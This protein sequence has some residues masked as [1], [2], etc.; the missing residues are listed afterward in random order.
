MCGG[1]KSTQSSKSTYTPNPE[2]KAFYSD[3]LADS[4]AALSPYDPATEKQ[5][6]GF[7]PQQQQAFTGVGALQGAYQ[8]YIGE[9]TDMTRAGGA[10]ITADDIAKF[11]N[12]YQD[13]TLNATLQR[14]N[15][16]N[17]MQTRDYTASQAAQSGLGGSGFHIGKAD[18]AGNQAQS[19]DATIADMLFKG[20]QSSLGAAQADKT[21]GLQAG[22]Q[23]AGLGQLG[24]QLGYQDIAALTQ[25]GNQQ[26]AQTQAELDAASTNALNEQLYPMQQQQWLASIGSGIGPLMGGTTTG[27]A[28]TEQGK[29]IGNLIG[30]AVTL[31]GMASDDRVKENKI[32][33]G[34]TF[35]GQTIWKYNYKGDPR[36]QIGLIAQEVEGGEHPEAVRELGG[37][38]HVNY[39]EA[40]S[41]SY[42]NGG[43]IGFSG[44]LLPW[45]ELKASQPIIP[46]LPSSGGGEGQGGEQN[47]EQMFNMGKKAGAGLEKLFGGSGMP[48]ASSPAGGALA[49]SGLQ[50][51]GGAGSAGGMA[52]MG[53]IGSLLGMF[54]F[55]DGGIV[56]GLRGSLATPEEMQALEMVESGG[57][58]I[59]GPVTRSGERAQGPRQ[60]MPSTARDP[61]FGVAPLPP[62]AGVDQQRQ[63]SDAYFNAMLKR[64]GGDRDAARIA[65]NGGPARADAWLKA[66]RDDSVIPRES[67]DYYK[68]IQRQLTP[69]GAMAGN[70]AGTVASGT[71][72]GG[73]AGLVQKGVMGS[74]ADGERYSGAKDRATGGFLKSMFGIEF[75][76]LNLNENERKAL[77]VAGLSMM[78]HG[79]VGRGGLAGMQYLAGA[80]AGERDARTEAQKLMRQLRQDELQLQAAARG[81]RR[82]ERA[83]KREERLSE[84]DAKR[85]DL[86]QKEYDLK[87][88]TGPSRSDAAKRAIDAGLIPG[89]PEYNDYVLK[90]PEKAAKAAELP[91]EIG[92]RIGLGREFKKDLPDLKARISKFGATDYADL[93]VGR[94]NAGEVWR[95]IE[96]GRDALVRGLTGA[97]IGVAEA[98][99]QAARYQIGVTD[100]PETMISKL[101][102]LQRDLD[103]VER[104]AITGKTGE[105]ARDYVDTTGAAKVKAPRPAGNDA[106]IKAWAADAIKKGAPAATVNQRLQEWGVQP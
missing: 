41:D 23:M 79:D 44:G 1:A 98:Q 85:L 3:V 13:Q 70:A 4:R 54:G 101:E 15:E 24:S 71:D 12:P 97:G 51:L 96:S 62:G 49:A 32:P 6:A 93:A 90:G 64:Y 35:D 17:A 14:L 104:G 30:G 20:W 28:T 84:S 95:R 60:I 89:T 92:A 63:F 91:G 43:G 52:S 100:R 87:V 81:E 47:Y 9:A 65:Y 55:A 53:G 82:E 37:V 94:G 57:R 75:N 67:A 80:E 56:D 78:S 27:K 73:T 39:D 21:R 76:P 83:D 102:S 50:G 16:Q 99:N 5:V 42:A 69:G 8:P 46:Q 77:I 72:G 18:L 38:K 11:M 26:Q 29:G 33:I 74:P 10:G 22:Q 68:K 45:A 40:L 61:G 88:K 19:R 48:A 103:A 25:A 36:S 66:G 59:Q 7:T 31:A 2:A 86:A 106:Q 34:Q 58:D 105:M